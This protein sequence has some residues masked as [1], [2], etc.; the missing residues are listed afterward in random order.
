M[1]KSINFARNTCLN[2][3]IKYFQQQKIQIRL[4][5]YYRINTWYVILSQAKKHPLF[6]SLR[7]C[8]LNHIF[9]NYIPHLKKDTKKFIL[10]FGSACSGMCLC[11]A[12]FRKDH[13]FLM[14]FISSDTAGQTSRLMSLSLSYCLVRQI[15]CRGALSCRHVIFLP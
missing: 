10:I 5:H 12:R 14:Q 13:N 15:L 1:Y 3:D 9:G 8:E 11:M 7:R 4:H 6:L 2:I